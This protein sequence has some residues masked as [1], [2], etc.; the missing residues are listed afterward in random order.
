MELAR[1]LI[2]HGADVSAQNEDGWM[3]LHLALCNSQVEIACL[4][5][6]HGADLTAKNNKKETPT[7]LHLV[8]TPYSDLEHS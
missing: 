2:K 7:P 3:P 5:I 8:P 1:V 4:L 6:E